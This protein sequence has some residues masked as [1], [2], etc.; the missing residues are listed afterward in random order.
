MRQIRNDLQ[1]N[2]RRQ[3]F[4]VNRQKNSRARRDCLQ[5]RSGSLQLFFGTSQHK[6][7]LPVTRDTRFR[8]ASVSKMFTVF[9]IL[10]LVEQGKINLDE[11][12]GNYLG[13]KLRNPNFPDEKITVRMLA[14]H[15]STL[16]D[17]KIYSL[18][19]KFSLEKFFNSD[20]IVFGAENKNFFT[21]CN[22]NYG[23]LGTIIEK[24]TGERFD[25]YQ[26]KNIFKQ[27]EIDADYVV[28]N[29]S[30]ENF[31]NLGVLYQKNIAQIDDYKAKPPKNFVSVQ[32]PYLAGGDLFYSLKN[33]S[34]GT[35]ATIFSP[36]GG[37][38][39]S[40]G[41]LANCLEMFFNKGVFRGKKILREDLL[42][43][44]CKPQWIYD[45][46]NPNGETLGVM[47][48]YGLGIYRIDGKSRA[49]FCKNFAVDFIGHS[50]EAYGMISG[51]YFR[52]GK[53]DGLIFMING[54]EIFAGDEKS[55]G[56][57]SDNFVWEE[58]IMN[59]ICEVFFGD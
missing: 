13:F 2:S 31:E 19:P 35:N 36:Q 29:F 37:L 11:D 51:L 48:N 21:Y 7:K 14:S 23:I 46:K 33:Y 43:E 17:G 47:L 15:T 32:N 59:P 39:I 1:K 6:K 34:V 54:T 38:R 8:V 58:E 16:R 45:E 5:R 44:M 56:K 50:G 25:L 20:K 41:E 55:F 30:A 24:V 49:R 22:L 12:A 53:K 3:I 27:L 52:P 4:K 40:F 28:G 18:S 42:A 10:Q 9:T 26:K 57:F